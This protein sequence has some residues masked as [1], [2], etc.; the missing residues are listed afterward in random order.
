MLWQVTIASIGHRPEVDREGWNLN[1]EE[2]A[3]GRERVFLAL[4]DR[5]LTK[6]GQLVDRFP[7]RLSLLA[8][9]LTGSAFGPKKLSFSISFFSNT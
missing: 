4:L 2:E 6:Q 9:A 8:R 7:N 1:R 5:T 3:T